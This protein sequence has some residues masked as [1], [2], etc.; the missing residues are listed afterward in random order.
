M[1]RDSGAVQ[2]S[3]NYSAGFD[4]GW[5]ID[6]FGG[7]RR[8]VE[9]SNADLAA[10]G[11]EL[12]DV[13]VSLVAEVALNYTNIRVYQAKLDAAE[14]NLRLQSETYDLIRWRR[15]AGLGDELELSQAT[16]NLESTRSRIPSL[17][18]GLEEAMNRAAILLGREPGSLHAELSGPAGIPSAP[19]ETAAGVP[20][21]R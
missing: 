3:E 8:S 2:T 6:I 4:A 14:T 1:E 19:M 10:A 11:E 5:E 13:L 17:E 7:T 21:E 15:E 9:A 20:A 18:T 12:R 16:Y